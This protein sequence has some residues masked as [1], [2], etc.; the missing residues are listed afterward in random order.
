MSEPSIYDFA[1]ETMTGTVRNLA[2]I[3]NVPLAPD[4]FHL[5]VSAAMDTLSLTDIYG[6]A[7]APRGS[8]LAASAA[9]NRC[10]DIIAATRTAITRATREDE[11]A[12]IDAIVA[13]V[14]ES[15]DRFIPPEART[16]IYRWHDAAQSS[17]E[18]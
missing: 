3:K 18:T 2:E 9:V 6:L 12:D 16:D 11:N 10:L 17:P 14:Q 8:V 7:K 5:V 15:P 1:I 4:R 13:R